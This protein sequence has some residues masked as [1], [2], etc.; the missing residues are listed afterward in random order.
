MLTLADIRSRALT[1]YRQAL[2]SWPDHESAFP[3]SLPIGG[4]KGLSIPEINR[5]VAELRKASADFSPHGYHLEWIEKNSRSHGKNL[6]PTQ[7][8]FKSTAQLAS[9]LDRYSEWEKYN[10]ALAPTIREFPTLLRVIRKNPTLILPALLR[11]TEILNV[12]RWRLDHPT[13][14]CYL[15]EIPVL[16]HSKFIEDNLALFNILF[17]ALI[18]PAFIKKGTRSFERRFGFRKRERF[19]ICRL[20]DPALKTTLA[21]PSRELALHPDDLSHLPIGGIRQVIIVENQVN[22]HT[23]PTIPGALAIHGGGNA[24]T[25][26][27]EADW[28][29]EIPLT[30]WGDLDVQGFEILASLRSH[31]PHLT[32][33]GMDRETL[34]TH[35]HLAT[36]GIPSANKTPFLTPS[37]ATAYRWLR[38]FKKRLEQERLPQDWLRR[39][40]K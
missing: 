39:I 37:E 34:A 23:L 36:P 21:W 32:S 33:F 7:A 27:S 30:Y 20:L 9:F 26:L 13:L 22:L 18:P 31:F 10:V 17:E 35:R 16:P 28:L 29:R 4:T 14:H 24:V 25:R 2:K 1:R 6:F 19:I 38:R 12:I 3:I 11:W 8:I 15:R 40:K 5:R